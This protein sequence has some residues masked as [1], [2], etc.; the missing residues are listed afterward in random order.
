M[1]KERKKG[2]KERKKERRGRSKP[3]PLVEIGHSFLCICFFKVLVWM[4]L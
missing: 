4:L 3:I 1:K 2:M